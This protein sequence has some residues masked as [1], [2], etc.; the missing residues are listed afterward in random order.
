MKKT[1][2]HTVPSSYLKW[3]WN[4][5]NWRKTWLFVLNRKNWNIALT[6]SWN[7]TIEKD[8]YTIFW[9][10]WEKN[11]IIED[12]FSKTIE[13]TIPIIIE[14]I[15]K[16][17][18]LTNQD[19]ID[20]SEFMAFQEMRSITRRKIDSPQEWDVLKLAIRWI[21]ENLK[22][23]NERKDS[24]KRFLKSNYNYNA[25][26][27][28]LEDFIFKADNWENILFEPR[29]H[30]MMIM[31]ELAPKIAKY[32]RIRQWSF[33]HSS[34]ERPF[35]VSDFPIYLHPLWNWKWLLSS[36]WYLTAKFIWF[37]ISRNCYMIAWD[38]I[39]FHQIPF[40]TNI[41]DLWMIKMFNL[42]T[43]YL[44]SKS[45]IWCNDKLLKKINEDI[46]KYD[47]II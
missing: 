14:K 47:K 41:T 6:T 24:L 8:F 29:K 4:T 13:K 25:T 30:N 27:K 37:P 36:P 31:L 2:Q 17:E 15:N 26:E 7:L 42:Q 11:Y 19:K 40:Y 5:L 16:K 12:F 21:F 43:A 34:K 45:L 3:F 23:Y 18:T 46:L 22:E 32:I 38:K 1:K 9:E 33:C 10:N 35:I 28:E 39:W 20:L 44:T